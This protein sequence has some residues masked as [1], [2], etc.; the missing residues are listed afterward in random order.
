MAKHAKTE[1]VQIET[2]ETDAVEV[3][4]PILSIPSQTPVVPTPTAG[5]YKTDGSQ[6]PELVTK[7]GSV[8]AAIRALDAEGLERGTI[9]K[10][11]GKRYQHVRNV[12]ITPLKK[13]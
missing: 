2:I 11:L 4:N 1:A 12:L 5:S 10:I 13:G 8:S 7:F 6:S 3:Q 9:G